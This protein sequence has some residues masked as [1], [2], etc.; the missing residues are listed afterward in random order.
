MSDRIQDL[1]DAITNPKAVQE[2]RLAARRAMWS[3]IQAEAP[4]EARFIELVTARFGKPENVFL[5]FHSGE[6]LDSANYDKGVG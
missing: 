3:R 1:R 4:N 5:R 2:R 6:V